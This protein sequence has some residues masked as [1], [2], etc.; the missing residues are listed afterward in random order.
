M[1]SV[2]FVSVS[3]KSPAMNIMTKYIN[4]DNAI[5][6]PNIIPDFFFLISPIVARIE[7][8]VKKTNPFHIQ[9]I[10]IVVVSPPPHP[11]P[12]TVIRIR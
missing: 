6:N 8:R 2:R 10:S 7:K 9:I 1:I 3:I 5:T 12:N 4:I 11:T